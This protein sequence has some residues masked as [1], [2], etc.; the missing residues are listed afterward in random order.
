MNGKE[1]IKINITSHNDHKI[2]KSI[3]FD[4]LESWLAK[5]G[6]FHFTTFG[7]TEYWQS[8]NGDLLNF[9]L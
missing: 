3:E 2:T 1:M 7:N 8:E 5:N 4:Q 6:Y 9:N